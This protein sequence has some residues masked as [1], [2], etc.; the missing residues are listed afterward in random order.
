[1]L[2]IAI[3]DPLSEEAKKIEFRYMREF[4][5]GIL[6]MFK[7][8]LIEVQGDTK[9]TF[10]NFLNKEKKD[11]NNNN[12]A[13]YEY[14]EFRYFDERIYE[15]QKLKVKQGKRN[16]NPDGW[17]TCHVLKSSELLSDIL[18]KIQRKKSIIII[19]SF[20]FRGYI[21]MIF[22]LVL[23]P[24]KHLMKTMIAQLY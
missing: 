4:I 2:I 8:K 16:S 24:S 18:E 3:N 6:Q 12:D 15:E 21:F 20:H 5:P 9:G 10:S 23:L 7:S 22:I 11:D 19:S 1:M 13:Y 14:V 17:K